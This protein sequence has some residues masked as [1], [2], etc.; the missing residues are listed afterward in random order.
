M[1]TGELTMK[2]T[3]KMLKNLIME[4][5]EE[6]QGS[7]PKYNEIIQILQGGNADVDTI[8]VMSGQNPHGEQAPED[9]NVQLKTDLES[10][11]REMGLEYIRIG[12]RFWG[13]WEQSVLILNPKSEDQMEKLNRDFGQWGFVYGKKFPIDQEKSFMVFTLY[14]VDYNNNMGYFPA[15]QE[16]GTPF[17][18]TGE[19]LTNDNIKQQGIEDYSFVGKGRQRPKKKFGFDFN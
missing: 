10:T 15:K 16:D 1:S 2:I 6:G 11:L 4:V 17:K 8:A 9:M 19:V 13:Q 3:N 18:Q 14:Q 7:L 12:G 5:L